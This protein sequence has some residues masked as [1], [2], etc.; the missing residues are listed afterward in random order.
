MLSSLV[1][2]AAAKLTA[3]N[4]TLTNGSVTAEWNTT[5]DSYLD[6]PK[7]FGPANDTSYDWYGFDVTLERAT[8]S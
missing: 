3:L 6:G 7:L 1:S 2:S 4:D 8:P 5:R